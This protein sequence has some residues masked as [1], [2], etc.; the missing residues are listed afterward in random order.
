MPC[1]FYA[2]AISRA[3]LLRFRGDIMA[4]NPFQ[5]LSVATSNLYVVV[6]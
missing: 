1:M 3:I 5:I 6:Y 2:Q 4:I